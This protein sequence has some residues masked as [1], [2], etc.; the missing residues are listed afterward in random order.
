MWSWGCPCCVA[1][2]SH[3]LQGIPL[4]L[5]WLNMSLKI[6]LLCSLIITLITRV[7]VRQLRSVTVTQ[8]H[9]NAVSQYRSVTVTHLTCD[10]N[11]LPNSEISVHIEIKYLCSDVTADF[12]MLHRHQ[13]YNWTCI[14]RVIMK[15]TVHIE[16]THSDQMFLHNLWFQSDNIIKHNNWPHSSYQH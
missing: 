16:S 2:E 6:T 3:W 15:L 5:N 14:Q 13:I 11:Y 7:T 4:C 8:C 1:G 12:V 9:R 10:E